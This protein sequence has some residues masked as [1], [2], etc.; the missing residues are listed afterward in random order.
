MVLTDGQ[1][2]IG[3]LFDRH[4]QAEVDGDLDATMATMDG[5]PHV[6]NLPTL[7][8]GHGYDGTRAFYAEQ[9]A[10]GFFPGDL[11][12]T[13]V[14]RTVAAERLVDEIVFTFTHDQ[15]L[16]WLLPG[17]PATGRRI[18]VPMVVI[19]GVADGKVSYE[20]IY[21]DQ[22]SVLVQAGLLDPAGLP[23]TGVE[24]AARLRD[25]SA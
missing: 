8:G 17:E 18:E 19:V 12:I 7:V 2:V 21:W 6:W 10:A 3:D 20:H 5:N 4:M 22:A 9:L 11:E 23:V 24:S 14:S 13:L 25:P 15:P 1:Q 16:E